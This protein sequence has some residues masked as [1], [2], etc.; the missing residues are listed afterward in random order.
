[1]K[2][3]SAVFPSQTKNP[4]GSE[5]LMNIS[6]HNKVWQD[7]KYNPDL[8]FRLYPMQRLSFHAVLY[9]EKKKKLEVIESNAY[10]T[11]AH[12]QKHAIDKEREAHFKAF[13]AKNSKHFSACQK[14][15]S[16]LISPTC[17][18]FHEIKFCKYYPF[19]VSL[20]QI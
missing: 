18:V 10:Q 2:I 11:H 6:Q 15:P 20:S 4:F 5:N 19:N 12:E 13:H 7:L 8:D 3:A 16:P 9:S 17:G 1:M 14:F